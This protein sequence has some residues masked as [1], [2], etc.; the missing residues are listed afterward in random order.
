MN[1]DLQSGSFR[2]ELRTLL[3]LAWPVVL[4][5]CGFTAMSIEDVVMVGRLGE[6]P[7]A[8]LAA[9]NIWAFGTLILG[10]GLM[11]GIDPVFAQSHGAGEPKAAGRALLRAVVLCCVIS[12]PIAVSQFLAEPALRFLGQPAEVIPVAAEYCQAL[13]WS[14]LPALVFFA[15]KQ[16]LQGLGL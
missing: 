12:V 5:Q 11:V 9:G 2:D 14:V 1:E 8:A 10:I 7:L 4:G 13:S 3:Q 6:I 15:L 16:F